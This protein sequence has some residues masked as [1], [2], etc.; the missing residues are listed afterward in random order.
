MV[1]F[2]IVIE[3]RTKR[4]SIYV[5]IVVSVLCRR[6]LYV[7][8]FIF[9]YTQRSDSKFRALLLRFVQAAT[10]R[11]LSDVRR[12]EIFRVPSD[13]THSNWSSRR[14]NG[15]NG[16][17]YTYSIPAPT[18]VY[19]IHIAIFYLCILVNFDRS[20]NLLKNAFIP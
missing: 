14:S 7:F 10:G 15:R 5:P 13:S 4:V 18:C 17:M 20:S 1:L 16:Q 8:L 19:T 3:R 2:K 11:M 9:S 6:S 12:T